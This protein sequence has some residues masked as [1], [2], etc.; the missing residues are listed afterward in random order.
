MRKMKGMLT[1]EAAVIVP[2]ILVVFSVL[3]HMLFYYHDKN[4]L[5][6]A[7][8]EAAAFG[9]SREV[10]EKTEIEEHFKAR[11]KGRLLLF[12]KIEAEISLEQKQVT[13]SCTAMKN[14]MSI[15]VDSA[16]SRTEPEDYIRTLRKIEK[17]GEK[18]GE[19]Q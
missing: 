19:E 5:L 11:I 10:S 14:S 2:M 13:V 1:V 9:S 3:L 18:A 12:S 16:V 8:H 7:A 17:I 4:I 6:A 15:Q